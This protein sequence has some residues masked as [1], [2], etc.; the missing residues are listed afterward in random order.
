MAVNDD[1]R[2]YLAD[3]VAYAERDLR[4]AERQLEIEAWDVCCVLCEQAV[5]RYL[6]ALYVFRHEAEPP[7]THKIVE[8][9]RALGAPSELYSRLH[10]LETDYI[11]TR[12]PVP[13][14]D[15]SVPPSYDEDTAR[16]RLDR[17]RDM[18]AW[19]KGSLAGEEP[20]HDA[21]A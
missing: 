11:R 15:A 21:G 14:G 20:E 9:A 1:M 10:I 4:S 13:F 19:V 8:L 16:N 17:A 6:K 2:A 7:R 5:E 12:Y 18:V 3:W